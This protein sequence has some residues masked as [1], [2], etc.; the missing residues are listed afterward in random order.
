MQEI[1]NHILKMQQLFDKI[2]KY[3]S[4]DGKSLE[5]GYVRK[6]YM[7]R[8]S[9]Y[10]GNKLIKVLV[11]QRR[12]GKS[13]ILRQIMHFLV[14]EKGVDPSN[15]FYTNKEF[16]AFDEIKSSAELERLFEFYIT[17]IKPRG[18]IYIF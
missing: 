11:G 1:F 17:R 9:G 7:E 15:I 4:W 10:I 13:Y 12:S 16:T 8:I 2:E 5:T 6:D 14:S 3:N 18:K